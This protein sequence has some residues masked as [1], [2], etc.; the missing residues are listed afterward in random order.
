[1]QIPIFRT[2]RNANGHIVELGWPVTKLCTR[3]G[4]GAE[5]FGNE[6]GRKY[7][8]QVK[9]ENRC[10]IFFRLFAVKLNVMSQTEYYPYI[11]E[12][13]N[14]YTH[15]K[16]LQSRFSHSL[17]KYI[18][19]EASCPAQFASSVIK[20]L[21]ED[22]AAECGQKIKA[23]LS[24]AAADRIIAEHANL[25]SN[26]TYGMNFR[27]S[28]PERLPLLVNDMGDV[29]FK[30]KQD[31]GRVAAF[32][33]FGATFGAYCEQQQGLGKMAVEK[34]VDSVVKYM[35]CNLK[36]WL[37]RNGGLVSRGNFKQPIK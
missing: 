4:P 11:F 22:L 15:H 18:D 23:I 30:E 12:L 17:Q 33:A 29:I 6:A 24:T 9:S 19:G 7:G 36:S 25:F 16:I 32:L 26:N 10:S 1:M 13:V 2:L 20:F 34:I 35:D 37:K 27:V 3:Q 21:G 28:T 8:G 31:V 14:S 5:Q